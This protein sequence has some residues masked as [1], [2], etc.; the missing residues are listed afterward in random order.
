M[1]KR[2]FFIST[3]F[4]LSLFV[5]T[6]VTSP[7]WAT[8]V[9]FKGETI[10]FWIPF[11]EGGGSDAWA[12]ALVPVMQK[13]LPG[14]PTIIV[15]N[16]TQGGGIGGANEFH[17]RMEPNGRMIFGTS[18]SIQV[19]FLL[20]DKRVRYDYADWEPVFA[21]PA[22]GV[23]YVRSDAGIQ[24][25]AD[26][27]KLNTANAKF[28]SQG[29]STLDLVP[30]LAFEM[31]GVNVK[32]VF[33]VK[34]RSLNRQ[35]IQRKELQI[36]YQTTPSYV[37][38]VKPLV[39][40]GEMV[41]LFAWGALNENGDIVRDPTFPDLPSF[42]EVYE[43]LN[44]D[45]PSGPAWLAWKAFFTAGFGTQKFIMLPKDTDPKIIAAYRSAMAEVATDPEAVAFLDK[46]IGKY[47]QITGE[48]LADAKQAATQV[49]AE[50][51]VWVTNWLREKYNFSN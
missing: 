13:K 43:M 25:A 39:D 36:D 41:A 11:K 4:V 1:M 40:N 33:G 15:K 30:L 2:R 48:Q 51:G 24:S 23:V 27:R 14:N 8:E 47:Q 46:R 9:S 17:R 38:H 12:R 5:G 44:G 34:S 20:K 45:K 21:T 16:N 37:K 6:A 49:P 18:G 26:I 19:P 50:A 35:A 7:T 31:L 42:P 3:G 28:G 29:V 22:G 32:A 10:E